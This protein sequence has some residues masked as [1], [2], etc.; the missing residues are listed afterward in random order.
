MLLAQ[1]CKKQFRFL[2][3][4]GR[5]GDSARWGVQLL[6]SYSYGQMLMVDEAVKPDPLDLESCPLVFRENAILTI[7]KI[8]RWQCESLGQNVSVFPLVCAFAFSERCVYPNLQ[9]TLE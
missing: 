5:V 7:L 3:T 8:H 4:I 2:S 9:S 6:K 1:L